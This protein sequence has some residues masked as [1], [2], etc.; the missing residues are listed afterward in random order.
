MI[1]RK[2]RILISILP[3]TLQSIIKGEVTVLNCIKIIVNPISE[4]ILLLLELLTHGIVLTLT[5]LKL[6]IL[7]LL[8]N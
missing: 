4:N 2:R 6:K 5:L 8:K 1:I 3:L 7:T